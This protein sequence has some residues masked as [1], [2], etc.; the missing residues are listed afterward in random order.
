MVGI[1]NGVYTKLK[2]DIQTLIHVPCICYSLQLA[3]SAAASETL[4]RNIEYMIRETYNWFFHS[5]LRQ[6]QYKI[7]LKP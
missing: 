4:A 3:V 2:E 1:N 7:Y 6:A 5:S